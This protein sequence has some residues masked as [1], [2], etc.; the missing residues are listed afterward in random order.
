MGRNAILVDFL[1]IKLNFRLWATLQSTPFHRIK[2][3]GTLVLILS[4]SWI[5]ALLWRRGL[6]NSVKLWAMLCRATQE[7]QVIVESSDK[8]WSTGVRNGK[9]FHYS[10]HEN[11]MNSMKRQKDITLEDE[12]PQVRRSPICYWGRVEHNY[13]WKNEE[14]GPKWKWCSV[15]NNIA[16]DPSMLGP[17]INVSWIW[18]NKR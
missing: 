13:S 9:L 5:I 7:G 17:W 2:E 18:S 4:P 6:C 8:T 11:P 3:K 14:A 16:Q 1:K 15:V 10:C 12:P